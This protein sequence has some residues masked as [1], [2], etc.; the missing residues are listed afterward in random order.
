[1]IESWMDIAFGRNAK[2]ERP[3]DMRIHR[4]LGELYAKAKRPEA[5]ARQFRMASQLVPRD[6][7]LL[8]RLGKAYLDAK[9]LDNAREILK[10]IEKL[11]EHAFAVNE[12]NAALKARVH[13]ESNDLHSARKVLEAARQNIADSY[14]LG[15]LLGQVYLE[16]DQFDAAKEV[17]GDVRRVLAKL[18]DQ[19]VWTCATALTAAL[20]LSDNQ[21]IDASIAALRRKKPTGEQLDSIERG[22]RSIVAKLKRDP[23]VLA[24]LRSIE[25]D[26]A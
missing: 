17:Y 2:D 15:D 6:I 22:A 13:R 23:S 7:F 10:S 1:V 12:E 25:Q 18:D 3:V 24:R 11:D 20:V 8:R 21:Q 26:H 16:L 4:R 5:A 9:D 19:S 14:Y